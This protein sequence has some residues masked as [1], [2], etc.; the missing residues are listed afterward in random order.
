MTA[1]M[2]RTAIATALLAVAAPALA[3]PAANSEKLVINTSGL[4][5]AT[6]AGQRAL[7]QRIDSAIERMCSDEVFATIDYDAMDEC[8]TATRAEVQPQ[9]KAMM[10][11]ATLV[12]LR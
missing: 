11:A 10:P 5:L 7:E 8:R 6:P 9:I 2:I 4:N 12:A 1:P 3:D